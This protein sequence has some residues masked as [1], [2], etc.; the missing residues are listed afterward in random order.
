MS[1]RGSS[2]PRELADPPSSPFQPVLASASRR[3]VVRR[4][5][6]PRPTSETA[7]PTAS[8]TPF[9]QI[10]KE[11][12]AADTDDVLS[13]LS[14]TSGWAGGGDVDEEAAAFLPRVRDL[15]Q[16]RPV[17]RKRTVDARRP[18]GESEHRAGASKE[19]EA[20]LSTSQ[21]APGSAGNAAPQKPPAETSDEYVACRVVSAH[22]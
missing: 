18:D 19:G 22:V 15:R 13:L 2:I 1:S 10:G 3:P 16:R 5:L 11:D 6:P 9:G 8:T 21:A 17:V 20:K 4:A 7:A 12:E 14:G